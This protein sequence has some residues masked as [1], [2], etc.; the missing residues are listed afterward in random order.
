MSRNYAS[1]YNFTGDS[2]A[3]DQAFYLVAESTKGQLQAPQ[4]ADFIFTLGGGSISFNQP[5]ES[6]PHR[7]G[8]HNLNVIKKKK[9][10]SW[11]FSTYFNIDETLGSPSSA[12]VDPAVRTLFKSLLG[13]ED[14]SAG[15]VYDSS[16]PP[17]VTFTL[18]EVGDKWCRQCRAA[19]VNG[20]NMKFPGDGE[21]MVEWSGN[22]KDSLFIGIGKSVIDNSA[23]NTV[24]LGTGEGDRFQ[25]G[26]LV[27]IIKAD[28]TTR[29]SDTAANSSRTITDISTDV[30][31][32]SGSPLADADG[33]GMGAPIYLCYYEPATK[34]AINNPVT[35][36]TGSIAISG[37]TNP[38]F[39]AATLNVQ[40]NHE[41]ADYCFGSDSL[42]SPFF[43]PG[44]RLTAE[45]SIEMNLNDEIIAFFNRVQGF[46]AQD[47]TVNLGDVSG[48]YF[49]LELPRVF[50][51]VPEFKVPETGSIPVTFTGNAYETAIDE[52]DEVTAS[53][54]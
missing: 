3:L 10:T 7:S 44:S 24:T 8:R 45:L 31:T 12:E 29:S 9:V 38:C 18:F 36:L 49:K 52:A 23:G 22:A 42:A 35:G 48:R 37:V 25:V 16:V 32:L 26:G 34:T 30:I 33:S 2:S 51:P 21:A 53:F 41:L 19:F 27:M 14:T 28:G 20:G 1:I 13:F 6:S 17:D 39:R 50:F 4:P 43:I 54:I 5:F 15:A 11:M 47:I 46:E 40:N